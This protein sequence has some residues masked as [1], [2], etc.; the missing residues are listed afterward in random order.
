MTASATFGTS[1]GNPLVFENVVGFEDDAFYGI[2]L[3]NQTFRFFRLVD[4]GLAGISFLNSGPDISTS[5]AVQQN[6]LQTVRVRTGASTWQYG[7]TGITSNNGISLS[8]GPCAGGRDAR[9]LIYQL[10][11]SATGASGTLK[12]LALPSAC[13]ANGTPHTCV[14][15]MSCVSSSKADL[16]KTQLAITSNGTGTHQ[17]VAM[18]AVYGTSGV[19]PVASEVFVTAFP[20]LSTLIAGT[21]ISGGSTT[22]VGLPRSFEEGVAS[23]ATSPRVMRAA[24]DGAPG[25]VVVF[26]HPTSKQSVVPYL[27]TPTSTYLPLSLGSAGYLHTTKQSA[28]VTRTNDTV[29]I[30]PAVTPD[31]PAITLMR[32]SAQSGESV[33]VSDQLEIPALAIHSSAGATGLSTSF[34]IEEYDL[35]QAQPTFMQSLH[36]P[37]PLL[38]PADNATR[39]AVI[40]DSAGKG[41]WRLAGDNKLYFH[42]RALGTYATPAAATLS[43]GVTLPAA[44]SALGVW[45]L[46]DGVSSLS[47]WASCNTTWQYAAASSVVNDTSPAIIDAIDLGA[48]TVPCS[49]PSGIAVPSDRLAVAVHRDGVLIKRAERYEALGR[50]DVETA[51][52]VTW[53]PLHYATGGATFAQRDGSGIVFA[54]TVD[55]FNIQ[56]VVAVGR[57]LLFTRELADGVDISA[58][59]LWRLDADTQWT[60]KAVSLPFTNN[61]FQT[62]LLGSRRGRHIIRTALPSLLPVSAIVYS[63]DGNVLRPN[64]PLVSQEGTLS[65]GVFAGGESLFARTQGAV[66]VFR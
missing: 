17:L 35:S 15:G 41:F 53:L 48:S 57:D 54:R 58:G 56:H 44:A 40:F 14:A 24:D 1:Q 33:A 37:Y 12:A 6:T 55:G 25:P 60:G 3:T 39:A 46:P 20:A 26:A 49:G 2:V 63:W 7:M 34:D 10:T 31:N 22:L 5:V 21:E 16:T 19:T 28:V 23:V 38:G 42:R 51:S 30:D 65:V 13:S 45:A 36:F 59:M 50:G 62:A 66:V 43:A 32:E 18:T 47:V 4:A 27:Y 61:G 8:T 52:R 64:S 29:V 9:V 11:M